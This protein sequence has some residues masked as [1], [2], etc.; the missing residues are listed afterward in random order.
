MCLK[1]V[2][3]AENPQTLYLPF[4]R[5]PVILNKKISKTSLLFS[6]VWKIVWM[7]IK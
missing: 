2:D 1:Q 7:C 5:F 4:V 3:C 6:T